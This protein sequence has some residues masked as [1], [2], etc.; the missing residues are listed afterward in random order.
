[1][2]VATRSAPKTMKFYV[3]G[4]QPKLSPSTVVKGG[5][6]LFRAL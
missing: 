2:Y 3:Q 4:A 5:Q 1:M 6:F